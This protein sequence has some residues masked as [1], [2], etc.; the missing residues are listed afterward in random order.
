LKYGTIEFGIAGAVT[1]LEIAGVLLGVRIV[2]AVNATV[3]RL[4]VAALCIVVGLALIAREL[5]WF[6]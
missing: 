4:F 2:H 3:L 1:L 5:G 6:R